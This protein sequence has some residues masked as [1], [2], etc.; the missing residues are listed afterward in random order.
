ME[1]VMW[2]AICRQIQFD[3]YLSPCTKINSNSK[4][5]KAATTTTTI[6]IIIIN[7]NNNNNK[8]VY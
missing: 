5:I 1:L 4:W 3:P 2:M 6:I 7:N 8:Q